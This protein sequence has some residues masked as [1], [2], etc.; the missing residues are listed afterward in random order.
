MIV[1][2]RPPE[3]QPAIASVSCPVE[4]RLKKALICSDHNVRN[5]KAFMNENKEFYPEKFRFNVFVLTA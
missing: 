2:Q 4:M 5:I 3:T 1:P